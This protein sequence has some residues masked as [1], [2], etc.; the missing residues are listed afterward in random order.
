MQ[1]LSYN[2]FILGLTMKLPEY[3]TRATLAF[4]RG[5]NFHGKMCPCTVLE[6]NQLRESIDSQNMLLHTA[7]GWYLQ[8]I[9]L[10]QVLLSK[11]RLR[12]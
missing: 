11:S 8:Q 9:L 6:L 5:K 7:L 4:I 1:H 10:G 12:E 2:I 3:A